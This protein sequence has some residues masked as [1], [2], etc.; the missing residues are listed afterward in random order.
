MIEGMVKRNTQ[1]LLYETHSHLPVVTSCRRNAAIQTSPGAEGDNSIARLTSNRAIK[2]FYGKQLLSSLKKK[3]KEWIIPKIIMPTKQV[4]TENQE[5][6][7]EN[8]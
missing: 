3:L 1:P 6:L 2:I 8:F 7:S 5:N 4:D